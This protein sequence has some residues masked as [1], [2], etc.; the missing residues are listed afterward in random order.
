[1]EVDAMVRLGQKCGAGRPGSEHAR[2]AL[3][4]EFVLEAAAASM[5]R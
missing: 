4:A 3:D 2:P 5:R 1:V